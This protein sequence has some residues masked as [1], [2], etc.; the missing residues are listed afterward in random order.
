MPKHQTTNVLTAPMITWY[1]LSLQNGNTLQPGS[2]GGYFTEKSPKM[3][4]L[5]WCQQQKRQKPRYKVMAAG[6]IGLRC[7]VRLS[8]AVYWS[9]SLNRL[10]FQISI[11]LSMCCRLRDNELAS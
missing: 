4:L 9:C 2:K 7:K 6:A 10:L 5:E 8:L 3:L 11:T 1:M